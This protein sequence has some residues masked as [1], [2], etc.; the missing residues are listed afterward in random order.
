MSDYHFG[1]PDGECLPLTRC[2]CG[3]TYPPWA[4]VFGVDADAPTEMP[5][6][7]R[8]LYFSQQ[9]TIHAAPEREEVEA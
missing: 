8:R 2:A 4:L 5:C 6:C 7:Q 9:I 3:V 1:E